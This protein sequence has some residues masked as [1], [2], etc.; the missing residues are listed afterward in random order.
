MT[1]RA[2]QSQTLSELNELID[3]IWT[4]NV[5]KDFQQLVVKDDFIPPDNLKDKVEFIVWGF[6]HLFVNLAKLSA[7]F[8][9]QTEENAN[10]RKEMKI[11]YK[12]IMNDGGGYELSD[13]QST[14]NQVQ[15]NIRLMLD[16]YKLMSE[17]I[18]QLKEN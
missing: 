4:T 14:L 7:E 15:G 9:D 8:H 1:S 10:I 17:E 2:R 18:A 3:Q 16:K 13:N 5:V 12:L 6:G 11:M